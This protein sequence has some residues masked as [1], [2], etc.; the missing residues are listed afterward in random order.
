MTLS[1]NSVLFINIGVIA[2]LVISMI[3]GYIRGFLWQIIKTIGI[4]A[5]ILLS[6]ILAPGFSDLIKVFPKKFAPFQNTQLADVFY[7]KIN[8]LVWFLII[9]LVGVVLIAIIKP[10]FK[11]VLEFPII[12]QFNSILGALFALI[13]SFIVV[14][15]ITFLLN[16]AIFTNG[17]D[18]ID[19][20]V[21]KYTN[22]I[23]EKVT[24]ILSKSFKEN[25]AIQKMISDPLSLD[26]EDIKSIIEWLESSS[27]SSEDIYEFLINYGIDVEKLNKIINPGE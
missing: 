23:T 10:L 21:L 18:I 15:L 6:W 17:K 9:F 27:I 4:L 16:T 24:N 26:V 1:S 13:P 22:K 2:F 7:E 25:V 12:K 8:I 11:V 20:S 5:V 14:I 19:K 3:I